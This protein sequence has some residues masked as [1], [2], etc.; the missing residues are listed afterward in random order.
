MPIDVDTKFRLKFVA[1]LLL[2]TLV[3]FIY[4]LISDHVKQ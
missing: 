3:S 2:F 1:V 4:F